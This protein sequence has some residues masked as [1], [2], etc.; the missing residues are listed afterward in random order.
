MCS[1]RLDV[2]AYGRGSCRPTFLTLKSLTTV[3]ILLKPFPEL[4]NRLCGEVYQ[5]GRT[6]WPSSN[7]V[8]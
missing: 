8:N 4:Q 3:K 1:S 2:P 5:L 7:R 6:D